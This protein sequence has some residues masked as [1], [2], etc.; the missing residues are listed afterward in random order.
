MLAAMKIV[1]AVF[2]AAAACLCLLIVASLF[3]TKD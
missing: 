3:T 1:V 2:Y